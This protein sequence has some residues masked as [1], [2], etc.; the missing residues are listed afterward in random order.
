MG[1]GPEQEGNKIEEKCP[2]KYLASA[3]PVAT[4]TNGIWVKTLSVLLDILF[5]STFHSYW[6]LVWE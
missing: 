4:S 2:F 6:H 5:A 3:L 1:E